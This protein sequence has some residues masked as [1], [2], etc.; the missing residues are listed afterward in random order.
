MNNLPRANTGHFA[1]E[2]EALRALV[3]RLAASL[4]PLTIWLFGSR[5]SGRQRPDSDFDLLVV[6]RIEDGEAGRDYE[7]AYAPV[8][9]C[10]IGCDI[11]PIRI[12]DFI[13]E[14]DHP[15]S[16]FA[17][18]ARS[19]IKVYGERTGIRI[20][21]QGVQ[22]PSEVT[23]EQACIILGVSRRLVMRRVE[24][25][26]LPFRG[27]GTERRFA[28]NDVLDLKVKEERQN[29]IMRELFAESEAL[30]EPSNPC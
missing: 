11:V 20:P 26:R 10:G 17:E 13:D 1:T 12:D 27:I 16:M 19:G 14:L 23:F 21:P 3:E 25:G 29:C 22:P 15:T 2:D 30:D 28:L 6:T 4:N 8:C 24:D 5:A 7:R 9:G 18:I